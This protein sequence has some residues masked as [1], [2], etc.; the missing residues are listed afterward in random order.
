MNVRREWV[1]RKGKIRWKKGDV[2]EHSV[3]IMEGRWKG[4]HGKASG[5]GIQKKGWKKGD[6]E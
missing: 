6:R 4:G 1:Q 3:G 5:D 2:K